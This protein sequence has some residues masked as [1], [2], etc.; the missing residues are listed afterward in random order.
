MPILS[1]E[2]I[3]APSLDGPNG[4]ER[5]VRIL[6]YD[7]KKKEFSIEL[8]EWIKEGLGKNQASGSTQVEA[9]RNF[10]DL[11]QQYESS[12]KSVRKVIAYKI[13]M[14]GEVME[15]EGED[16]HCIKKWEDYLFVQGVI[17]GISYAVLNE[18]T[19]G[20][21]KSY[22]EMDGGRFEN[23]HDHK[24]IPW[25]E[26]SEAFFSHT[27]QSMLTL[28]LKIEEFFSGDESNVVKRIESARNLLTFKEDK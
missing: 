21:K 10:K 19:V 12:I 5:F 18:I 16:R 25:S 28:M 3:G 4:F 26:T 20:K 27:Q 11:C 14:T 1:R 15:G 23:R 24:I 13:E 8:P 7:T 6:K 9:E 2:T 17:L 22:R